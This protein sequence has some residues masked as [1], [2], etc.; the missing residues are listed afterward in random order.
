MGKYH[1]N[2]INLIPDMKKNRE[3]IDKTEKLT[4]NFF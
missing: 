4:F 3:I 1:T 2:L